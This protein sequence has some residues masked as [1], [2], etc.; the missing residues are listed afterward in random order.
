MNSPAEPWV[1]KP[2]RR[3][4]RKG[5]KKTK[6]SHDSDDGSPL[7][8]KELQPEEIQ[9]HYCSTG[10]SAAFQALHPPASE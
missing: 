3:E 9:R 6:P 8:P 4:P 1:K 2:S 7:L 10:I 5:R